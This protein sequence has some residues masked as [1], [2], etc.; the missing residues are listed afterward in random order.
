MLSG[1][2]GVSTYITVIASAIM[3]FPISINGL[4]LPNLPFVLSIKA[5]I[6][7]SVKASNTL[8]PVTITE[9]N[10]TPR[11]STFDPKVAM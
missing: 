7:G 5:P 4:N 6:I 9:A 10:K 11:L 2:I 8:I 1:I 3:I